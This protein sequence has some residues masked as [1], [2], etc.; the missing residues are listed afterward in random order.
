[1]YLSPWNTCLSIL[2]AI[3][4]ISCAPIISQA[5]PSNKITKTRIITYIPQIPSEKRDGSCWTNSNIVQRSDVWRC[6]IGNEIFDPCYTARDKTTIICD[7][8]PEIENPTGFVLK[9]TKPLPIPDVSKGPF[10]SASMIELEDGTICNF[11]SGASGATD[12]VRIE[13]I[14]YSCRISSKNVVIFADV[15]PGRVWIAERGILVEQKT[16]DDLPP[17]LVKDLQK[18]RIRTVWQ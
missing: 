4:I 16:R 11:I 2:L 7:A 12:G 17:F 9:L 5:G 6:M 10:S 8:L 3:L 18:V 14:N 13:R 15:Q 1:M